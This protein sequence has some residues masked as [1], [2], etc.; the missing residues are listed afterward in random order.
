MALRHVGSE[1]LHMDK[2]TF[3]WIQL[4]HF[5]MDP[6]LDDRSLLSAL[7]VNDAYAHDYA[8][9]FDADST[10]TE[11]AV[12]G[13]WWRDSIRGDSFEPSTPIDAQTVLQT[14]AHEQDWVDP[15]YRQPPEVQARLQ[16]VYTLLR[17]GNLYRLTNPSSEHEHEYGW[18][19]GELGFHEFVVI[20]RPG[21]MIHL[22][23][24]SD[25]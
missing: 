5:A 12:H 20:D 1:I 15:H 9:P 18:V 4:T 2:G 3:M 7:V 24:A 14:W 25:D 11:P 19:T 23:V 22:V 6:A 10:V 8:T 16:K 13:R 21:R 17:S